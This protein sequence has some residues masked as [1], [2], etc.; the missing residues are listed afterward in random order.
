MNESDEARAV[1]LQTLNDIVSC[2]KFVSSN[3]NHSIHF[4]AKDIESDPNY[5][6]ATR[7][8]Y[9]SAYQPDLRRRLTQASI[10]GMHLDSKS[11]QLG[12][13]SPESQAG[14][15][16]V[17]KFDDDRESLGAASSR[18][19]RRS[20]RYS[21][22]NPYSVWPA[23]EQQQF[24]SRSPS[25]YSAFNLADPPKKADKDDDLQERM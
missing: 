24:K 6:N 16:P 2:S 8:A 15:N 21:V 1:K 22:A 9:R 3:L 10:S 23:S 11:E 25:I 12:P 20:L 7:N 18:N 13:R 17:F 19:L 4:Q 5:L 14:R